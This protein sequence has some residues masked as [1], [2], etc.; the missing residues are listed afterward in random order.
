MKYFKKKKSILWYI[1]TAFKIYM[2][3]HV[4]TRKV[5]ESEGAGEGRSFTVKIDYIN[6]LYYKVKE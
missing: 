4:R 1:P 2:V 5:K 3:R 6:M